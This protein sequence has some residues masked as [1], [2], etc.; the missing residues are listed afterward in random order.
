MGGVG[1]LKWV[2][3]V[4]SDSVSGGS[5]GGLEWVRSVGGLSEWR[6]GS[7]SGWRWGSGVGGVGEACEW[8]V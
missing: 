6:W 5:G 4:R 3:W 1:G 8:G 7:V 2:G